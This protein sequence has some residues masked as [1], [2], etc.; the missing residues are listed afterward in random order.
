MKQILDAVLQRLEELEAKS[1]QPFV[2]TDYSGQV[3]LYGCDQARNDLLTESKAKEYGG[4]IA[5]YMRVPSDLNQV[6]EVLDSLRKLS[7][8][9]LKILY[10]FLEGGTLWP[11]RRVDEIIGFSQYI[12]PSESPNALQEKMVTALPS[13]KR[14]EGL[15]VLFLAQSHSG[16]IIHQIGPLSS[17]MM[18]F[19]HLT[20]TGIC[21]VRALPE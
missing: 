7:A 19:A 18:M 16:G 1:K 15:G 9:D 20:P 12:N 10:K 3:L 14:L 21:L 13:F 4:V 11:S 17:Y 6:A 8:N 2:L 5:H